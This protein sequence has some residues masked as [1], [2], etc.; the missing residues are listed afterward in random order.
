MCVGGW[1]GLPDD[2]IT[3]RKKNHTNRAGFLVGPPKVLME[4]SVQG[5]HEEKIP[6][7]TFHIILT[8]AAPWW[9][10]FVLTVKEGNKKAKLGGE[11]CQMFFPS[12]LLS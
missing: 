12:V 3:G 7:D 10:I 2:L 8:E 6:S 5:S 1:G 4:T 9:H 11:K